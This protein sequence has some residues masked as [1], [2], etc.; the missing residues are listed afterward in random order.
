M[1]PE[2]LPFPHSVSGQENK[3]LECKLPVAGIETSLKMK[4]QRSVESNTLFVPPGEGIRE[5]KSS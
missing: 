3:E 2:Y 5:R 4:D 1:L